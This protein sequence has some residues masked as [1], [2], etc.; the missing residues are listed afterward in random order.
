[1]SKQDRGSG[2]AGF[3]L[4]ELLVVIAI[5]AVLIGLL[6]PA[7]QKVREAAN[8]AK[9]LNNL[10][11]IALA[12]HSYH[13]TTQAF[14][15]SR[16]FGSP[17]NYYLGYA[18]QYI[19]LLSFLEQ[20]NLWQQ[21]N[22][23]AVANNTYMGNSF[24]PTVCGLTPGSDIATPLA[25]LACPSDQF[26]SPPTITFQISFLS[27]PQRYWGV[28]SYL[29]NKYS[30]FS[31]AQANVADGIFVGSNPPV[32][33]VS[34]SDGT[35]NTILFGERYN[36]DPNWTT[37]ASKILGTTQVPFCIFSAWGARALFGPVG[38]GF[39]PLNYTWNQANDPY[40]TIRLF[41]D[42]SGHINGA[43]FAF[44]DG[45]VHFISNAINNA[46]RLAN[47]ETLL[48]ALSSRDGGEVV[49]AAQY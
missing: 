10:K 5:I 27:P 16:D 28:T 14:P 3:T 45:S 24:S 34:I 46:A 49:D 42:G 19:P 1:M 6:L 37:L 26:P 17:P 48:E 31:N 13:D 21:L 12:C 38:A 15:K 2:R 33:L 25:L 47:G 23:L 22:N 41:A 20:G 8:R 35:S 36:Y 7:V 4:V 40:G 39:P 43:N 30:T 18:T 9:C 11:Q 44:C 32:S 29:G